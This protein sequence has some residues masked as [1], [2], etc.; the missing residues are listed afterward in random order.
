MRTKIAPPRKVVQSLRL[1]QEIK[2]PE[3]L[4]IAVSHSR[5]T[6]G[7]WVIIFLEWP[8][9]FTGQYHEAGIGL[10]YYNARWYDS[11]L[12]RFAQAD[13]IVPSPASPQSLNRFSYV[14]GNPLR[15]R[16]PSGHYEFEDDP[17]VPYRPPKPTQPR[18]PR[19]DLDPL[20]PRQEAPYI[21]SEDYG[22][23]DRGHMLPYLAENIIE[24]VSHR[25]NN[26]GG[27]IILQAQPTGPR[28]LGSYLAYYERRYSVSEE[29]TEDQIIGIA[30]AIFMDAG[31]RWEKW[32]GEIAFGRSEFHIEDLPSNYL[33]FVSAANQW[34]EEEVLSQLGEFSLS[35]KSPHC[36]W[37]DCFASVWPRLPQNRTHQALVY[38]NKQWKS[39]EWPSSLQITPIDS[40]SNTWWFTGDASTGIL[41]SRYSGSQ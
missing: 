15:Y 20:P 40:S 24:Q 1:F 32:Q 25:I 34:S 36:A 7:F 22:W 13:T 8:K 41:G 12:G 37:S 17:D 19:N 29:A 5:N 26:G 31:E 14:L 38:K 4:G 3:N 16:D 10:Y 39:V 23:I 11:R 18:P 30:L 27:Q 9:R 33:G 21:F 28:I 2:Y 6:I 35:H